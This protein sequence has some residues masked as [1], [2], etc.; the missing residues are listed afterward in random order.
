MSVSQQIVFTNRTFYDWMMIS[1]A[2]WEDKNTADRGLCESELSRGKEAYDKHAVTLE[3]G[4]NLGVEGKAR[5][6]GCFL[7]GRRNV[8]AGGSQYACFYVHVCIRSR[9]ES[10]TPTD[11]GSTY[12]GLNKEGEGGGGLG[13]LRYQIHLLPHRGLPP[14]LCSAHTFTQRATHTRPWCCISLRLEELWEGQTG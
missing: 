8:G 14:L 9:Q 6:L 4:D 12:Q 7:V 3:E 13:I 5:R 10:F 11:S 1:F 2:C